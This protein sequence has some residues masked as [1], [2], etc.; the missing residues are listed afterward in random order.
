MH[1]RKFIK[2]Y[3]FFALCLFTLSSVKTLAGYFELSA[4]GSYYKYNFGMSGGQ[5]TYNL[6]K[7]IGGGVAYRLLSNTSL[8]FAYSYSNSLDVGAAD[9]ATL[10]DIYYINKTTEIT[11]YSINLVLNFADRKASFSP[12]ISGGGGYMIRKITQTGTKVDRITNDSSVAE[13]SSTPQEKSASANGSFGLKMYMT[14]SLALDLKGT[15]Y[16]TDLDKSE[17]YLHYS[18]TGG[19]KFLF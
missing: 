5:P 13:F 8:E 14:D 18:L 2:P 6:T 4:N 10:P 7:Q 9:I 16:A 3:Q 11:N 15:V 12:Y 1:F 19:V 17:I